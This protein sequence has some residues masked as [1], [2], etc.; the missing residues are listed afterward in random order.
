MHE[1]DFLEAVYEERFEMIE[2]DHDDW[3][4][5]FDDG[6]EIPKEELTEEDRNY[7]IEYFSPH[8]SRH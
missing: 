6:D 8:N 1:D 3:D 7:E 2:E 4:G 5:C